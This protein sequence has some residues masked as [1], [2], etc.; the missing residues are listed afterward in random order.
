MTPLSLL[1]QRIPATAPPPETGTF[2]I[3]GFRPGDGRDRRGRCSRVCSR[4][5]TVCSGPRRASASSRRRP[6]WMSSYGP[7]RH[8]ELLKRG[9]GTQEDIIQERSG[10]GH[11]PRLSAADDLAEDRPA[12][13]Q[14]SNHEGWN[15]RHSP[16]RLRPGRRRDAQGAHS[17]RGRATTL[18]GKDVPAA[19][20]KAF[21]GRRAG[22][23][24]PAS[25]TIWPSASLASQLKQDRAAGG[26]RTRPAIGG[27][28]RREEGL[29]ASGCTMTS[30]C[31][32][33]STT[34]PRPSPNCAGWLKRPAPLTWAA[35]QFTA[36]MKQLARSRRKNGPPP[37]K[38]INQAKV[39]LEAALAARR[40]LELKAA[41]PKEPTDFTLPGR[42]RP[43]GKLHPLTQVTDDI[44]RAFARLVL[45]SPTAPRSRTSIIASTR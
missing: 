3:L 28:H 41:L 19:M 4:S 33:R 12:S 20:V 32:Y 38:L 7:E 6:R 30:D 1:A 42:R 23:P 39:E 43:L 2:S 27:A 13:L 37:A 44:V 34:V 15:S 5:A 11:E 16:G 45:P 22:P 25:A 21:E 10:R 36:L 35:R 14:S 31:G 17:G 26:D 24:R 40:E 29:P 9:H 8:R 18:G